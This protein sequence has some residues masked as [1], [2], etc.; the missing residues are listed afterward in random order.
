LDLGGRA[1]LARAAERLRLWA[2]GHHRVLRVVGTLADLEGASTVAR[3]HL[4]GSTFLGCQWT[5]Q[6]AVS[7]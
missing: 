3:R 2:R 4:A 7:N 5:L 1:L 6:G